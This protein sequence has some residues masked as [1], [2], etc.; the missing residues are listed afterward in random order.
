MPL[1]ALET[2]ASSDVTNR[3]S[4]ALFKR[5]MH[6][7]L[8]FCMIVSRVIKLRLMWQPSLSKI[9]F[10]NFTSQLLW[11][12]FS[13]MWDY[14]KNKCFNRKRWIFEDCLHKKLNDKDGILKDA[15]T[16]YDFSFKERPTSMI[17][18]SGTPK[19][20]FYSTDFGWGKPKKHEAVGID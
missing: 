14:G 5:L 12:L 6:K 20:N 11:Q 15:A 2:M 3:I 13:N 18:I 17:T 16:W 7:V 10:S 1:P 19:L 9:K 8:I 4:V